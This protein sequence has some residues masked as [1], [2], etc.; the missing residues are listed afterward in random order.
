MAA[1]LRALLAV[2]D[3]NTAR[4]LEGEAARQCFA[5]LPLLVKADL[6]TDFA[7]QGRSRRPPRDHFNTLISC[8]YALWMNDCRSAL[9]CRRLFVFSLVIVST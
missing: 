6:R 2:P 1:G 9:Y 4:G 8:L 3:L 5:G 7:M